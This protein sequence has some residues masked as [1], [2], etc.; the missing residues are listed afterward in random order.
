MRTSGWELDHSNA[1]HSKYMLTES[2]GC[3][4]LCHGCR[5]KALRPRFRPW[6]IFGQ[7]TRREYSP[8]L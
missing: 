7:P 5:P 1:L 4:M 6:T 2:T 8:F 3:A